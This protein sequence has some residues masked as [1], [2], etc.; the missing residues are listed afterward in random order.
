M[1]APIPNEVTS[2]PSLFSRSA[3]VVTKGADDDA[4]DARSAATNSRD[5]AWMH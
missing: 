4:S 5:Y 2:E 3:A 1:T